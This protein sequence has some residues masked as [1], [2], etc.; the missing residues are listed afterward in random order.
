MVTKHVFLSLQGAVGE[1]ETSDDTQDTAQIP[2]KDNPILGH[3]IQKLFNI[4]SPPEVGEHCYIIEIKSFNF[5]SPPEAGKYEY[6]PTQ[7]VRYCDI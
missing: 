1:W 6:K 5:I 2:P 7:I 3:I 4:I